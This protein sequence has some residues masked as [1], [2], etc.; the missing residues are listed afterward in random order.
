M[1][2]MGAAESDEIKELRKKAAELDGL[3]AKMAA[4]AAEQKQGEVVKTAVT[5]ALEKFMAEK[6]EPKK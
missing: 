2:A 4:D 6:G 1:E 3:K 5:S